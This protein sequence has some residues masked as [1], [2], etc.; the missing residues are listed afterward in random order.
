MPLCSKNREF[1]MSKEF[2]LTFPQIDRIIPAKKDETIYQAARRNGVRIIG[3]CG[4]AGTCG[5]CAV[6]VVE[7]HVSHEKG[8]EL[9][10]PEG[11]ENKKRRK[12]SRACLVHVKSDCVIEIAP[13]SLAPV[14]RAEASG[15]HIKE[16]D[17]I[18]PM[19]MLETQ[20]IE[21]EEATLDDCRADYERAIAK[22]DNTIQ[23]SSND[24]SLETIAGL[25][26]I[27]RDNDWKV[28]ARIRNNR[29]MG[30]GIPNSQKLG[31][32]VD[33]GTTN[34]AAFLMDLD[35]GKRL[36]TLAIE[37]PQTAWGGDLIS[38]INHAMNDKEEAKNLQ[39]AALIAI[40]SLAHDLCH[41]LGTSTK[42]ILDVTICANTA[43]HHLLLGL[44]VRQ[45]GR[46]PFVAAVSGS[47]D[48]PCSDLGLEFADGAKVHLA[49]NIGGFVG[50]DHVTALLATQNHWKR[51]GTTL[52]MDIGTNTEISLIHDGKI[53]STSCPSGPAL[54]GG[55]I[56]CGM[57]A[58]EG[59]I[60]QVWLN[61]NG[62]VEIATINKKAPVGVCGSGVVDALFTFLEAGIIDA[63]GRISKEHK[64][65][66]IINGK[67]V[68]ILANDVHFNQGDIRSVQL[69][70]AAIR[71]GTELLLMDR[72]LEEL[73]IEKFIIAGAFGA[74][75]DVKSSIAIGLL[76]DLPIDRFVQVG[77]AAGAGVRHMLVS[78]QKREEAKQLALDCQFLELSSK[79]NFQKRFLHHIGFS[80]KPS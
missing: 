72:G 25:P 73:A 15:S 65:T 47:M 32:A 50:G 5:A 14:V 57:R 68:A 20:E 19:P 23:V 71:T 27:L 11:M 41:E 29:L 6:L 46:A 63:G 69:A 36:A 16:G 54:E 28:Q 64:Y 3:A 35:S 79:P 26:S 74:Y 12:W 59:A 9:P 33:L 44:P 7:G 39:N 17:E 4:G 45:L 10:T 38:R 42:N 77:N 13:R 30:F 34:A 58:A 78:K 76:P 61:D 49:A 1:E 22:L 51:Q 60:E 67:P 80:R 21:L 56:S 43:M 66:K 24:I 18:A 55:H 31:L 62:E 37:N 53:T 75:I 52:V 48:V 40:K 70:K 8:D 2:K